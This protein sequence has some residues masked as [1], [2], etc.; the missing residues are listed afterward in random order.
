MKPPRVRHEIPF[1][2]I[3]P[4]DEWLTEDDVPHDSVARE[5]AAVVHRYLDVLDATEREICER[6]F[7]CFQSAREIDDEMHVAHGTS[8]KIIRKAVQKIVQHATRKP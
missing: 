6:R 3:A 4:R 5:I 8:I 2:D 7:C 1:S